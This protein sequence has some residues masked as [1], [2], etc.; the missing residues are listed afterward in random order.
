MIK[1]YIKPLVTRIELRP[2]TCDACDACKDNYQ[3]NAYEIGNM[4]CINLGTHMNCCKESTG[5]I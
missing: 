1:S 3:Q 2:G 5:S 4:G